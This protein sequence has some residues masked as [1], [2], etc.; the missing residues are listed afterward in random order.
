[1]MSNEL[2][3]T[4]CQPR[5]MRILTDAVS[6]LRDLFVHRLHTVKTVCSKR[7]S[8]RHFDP[9]WNSDSE[10]TEV[11]EMWL[12]DA[13]YRSRK[14]GLVPMRVWRRR[15]ALISIMKGRSERRAQD[16][17]GVNIPTVGNT[18]SENNSLETGGGFEV[19]SVT[20]RPV[21][22]SAYAEMGLI[23]QQPR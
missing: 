9:T 2:I 7:F 18:T 12:E 3:I 16:D 19:L 5:T 8:S 15:S 10:A 17:A 11:L 13:V 20:S 14:N 23:V 6:A 22:A 1:M 21:W 4:Q